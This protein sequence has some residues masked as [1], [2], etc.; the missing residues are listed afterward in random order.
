MRIGQKLVVYINPDYVQ[1]T[2]SQPSASNKTLVYT[3][4]S[5]DTLW[6]IA[7]KYAGV[8]V[9]QIQKLNK[10]SATDL[11]PELNFRYHKANAV[12]LYHTS[13]CAM[14]MPRSES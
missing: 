7:K 12:F 2:T 3:V 10:I 8:T 13:F 5:G 4:R 14:R 9:S 6:G 11:K 1:S